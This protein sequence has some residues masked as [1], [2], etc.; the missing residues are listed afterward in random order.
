MATV[1][2]AR[3]VPRPNPR[4]I[5]A[6]AIWLALNA[7]VWGNLFEPVP[8]ISS[9]AAL[10]LAVAATVGAGL[11]ARSWPFVALSLAIPAIASAVG[12][13][14]D[15]ELRAFLPTYA[16]LPAVIAL[17]VG[18]AAGRLAPRRV[19]TILGAGLLAFPLPRTA[20]AA[21]RT[22]FPYDAR[23]SQPLP[24]DVQSGSFQGISLGQP[25]VDALRLL[26]P[27]EPA[28]T[29]PL[30]V[31]YTPGDATR[32]D[33]PGVSLLTE[34]GH[35]VTLFITDPRAQALAGVG[36]GDNLAVARARLRGLVCARSSEDV[37]T[38]AARS[39]HATVLFVGDPIETITL[40]SIDTGWCFISAPSC[41][42][43]RGSTPLSAR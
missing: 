30:G 6:A 14:S 29:S 17:A 31:T 22:L 12:Y 9:S 1:S 41:R 35:V 2:V 18:V 32:T 19:A 43:P 27:G 3:R 28:A 34:H 15:N 23:P 11:L 40:S 8:N 39:A 42:R 33:A 25:T 37:P 36:V 5:A 16:V 4:P 10:A 7:A 21:E 26:P 24:V 20:F 38:C 13:S